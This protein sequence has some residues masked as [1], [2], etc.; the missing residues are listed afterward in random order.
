MAWH[1]MALRG[2]LGSECGLIENLVFIAI[3]TRTAPEK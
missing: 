1:G 2:G 3:S